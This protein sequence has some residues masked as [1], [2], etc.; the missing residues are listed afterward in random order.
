ML[1]IAITNM[2]ERYEKNF[3][4]EL[5]ILGKEIEHIK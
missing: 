2:L 5:E 4:K 1:Q 3:I